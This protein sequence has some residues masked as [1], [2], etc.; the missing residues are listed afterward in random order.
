MCVRQSLPHPC[1]PCIPLG[2]HQSVKARPGRFLALRLST[3]ASPHS[4]CSAL[5]HHMA[6]APWL[7]LLLG[8][9]TTDMV[10]II[11]NPGPELGTWGARDQQPL[12]SSCSRVDR[13]PVPSLLGC[14]G[15]ALHGQRSWALRWDATPYLREEGFSKGG[16]EEGAFPLGS[17]GQSQAT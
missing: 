3:P 6:G 5:S 10:L 15:A 7:G 8:V 13:P 11:P 9:W 14:R 17:G 1:V 16:T 12:A 2:P 4:S